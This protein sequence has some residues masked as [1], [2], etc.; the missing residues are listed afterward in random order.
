MGST[1]GLNEFMDYRGEDDKCGDY[2]YA[3]GELM[4]LS[5]FIRSCVLGEPCYIGGLTLP[6]SQ[7]MGFS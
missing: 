2:I 4:T 7:T 1:I 3:D 6:R 5:Q